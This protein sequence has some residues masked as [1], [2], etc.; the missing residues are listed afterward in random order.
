MHSS[1]MRTTPS[2]PYGGVCVCGGLPNK[3]PPRQR[4][5]GQ[6]PPNRDSLDRDPLDRDP[7]DRDSLDRDP[8]D[9]DPGQRPPH[10]DSPDETSQTETHWTE[11]P[12]QRPPRQ[13]PYPGHVTSG[14]SWD[15]DSPVNR[16]THKCKN[17]TL[18][19]TSFACGDKVDT[20]KDGPWLVCQ[21]LYLLDW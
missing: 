21:T 3:D 11:T 19:Q 20:T 10:R 4:L 1:R 9:R 5:P 18:L 13:R 7:L 14:A 6:R 8:L 15:R 17:I 12:G 16:M 2:L